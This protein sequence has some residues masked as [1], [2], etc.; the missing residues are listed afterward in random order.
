LRGQHG[1]HLAALRRGADAVAGGAQVVG[2][3][4][5]QLAVV[6]DEQQVVGAR[7]HGGAR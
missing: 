1:A 7:V 6:V 2:Q 3:Q 4:R 5:Q